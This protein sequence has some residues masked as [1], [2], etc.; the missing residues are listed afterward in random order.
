[1]RPASPLT[2][3]L[4]LVLAPACGDDKGA[5]SDTAATESTAATQASAGSTG[6]GT[7]TTGAGADVTWYQDV[8]PIIASHCWTCH[9]QE[10]ALSFS[11]EEYSAAQAWSPLMVEKIEG[12]EATPYYMPPFF[13]RESASC[14]PALPWRDDP[15]LDAAEIETIRAWV[16]GGAA[17]GDPATAAEIPPWGPEVL[18]GDTVTKITSAG[19]SL[20]ASVKEDQ[21][22]CFSLDPALAA[23]SWITGLQVDPGDPSVVHHVVL[24]S[25]PTGASAAK[26]A[27]EGSYSCF[28]GAGVPDSSVLYAWAPGGNPLEIP[29]GAGIPVEPGQRVVMQVH[30]H[31]T[32]EAATDKTGLSVRWSSQKPAREALMAIIGGVVAG[33]TNS[34]EWEDPPFLIPAGAKD[35]VETWRETLSVPFGDIRIWSIFPHM[36]LVGTS[37]EVTLEH[38]G[39]EACIAPL[40]KWD[41][42]WQRTYVYDGT[43]N[44]LP[45]V[46]DGDVMK[47]RCTYN[48][49]L[50]NPVL[51]QALAVEGIDAPSDVGV[52]EDTLDEMCVAIVGIMY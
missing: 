5:S 21:Y 36:H 30:Y 45:R 34:S 28:G 52:G 1:M 18:S 47:V 17:E 33:Q 22:R 50:D 14:T 4:A 40:P 12:S 6:E 31:P 42:D 24:F 2:V 7:G 19:Y 44:E 41:F 3:A 26:A 48:N 38:Q 20:A 13:A 37:I 16:D 10:G 49:S 32:G 25:D 11:L 39:A 27:G 8:R 9:S 51:A 29:D 23:K 43:F 46:Y 15:R 35:H